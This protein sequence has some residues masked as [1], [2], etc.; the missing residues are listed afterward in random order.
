MMTAVAR[1]LR[2]AAAPADEC[3]YTA[4][5]AIATAKHPLTVPVIHCL[6]MEQGQIFG[7][8]A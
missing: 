5:G 3:R 2:T 4:P 1:Q 6:V 8:Q 7:G